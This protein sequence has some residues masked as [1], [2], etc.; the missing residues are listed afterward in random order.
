MKNTASLFIGGVAILAVGVIFLIPKGETLHTGNLGAYCTSDGTLSDSR[1]IQS[2]RS[3]CIRSENG[4]VRYVANVPARY[5]F[6]I[7]D[8]RGTT[9]KNFDTTHTKI[10]HVIVVRKDLAYFDHVHPSFDQEDGVFVLDGLVFPA[11][12]AYRV[13][14]DFVP[15]GAQ[16]GA[17]GKPLGVTIFEDLQVGGR[18]SLKPLGAER[19]AGTFD[20]YK[21][22][23]ETHGALKAGVSSMLMFKIQKDNAAV[24]NL[25][26]YLG[27][28]GHSV[29][30]RE[31]TLDFIHA[32]PMEDAESVQTGSV[33]F[34]VDFPLAGKYKVFGQ[35]Q[36]AGKVFTQTSLYRCHPVG[37]KT[38]Q[39]QVMKRTSLKNE[40]PIFISLCSVSTKQKSPRVCEEIFVW[41]FSRYFLS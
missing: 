8:D 9:V 10:M 35:F 17:G 23:L 3:Y 2:H 7:I 6:S 25:E 27:A 16:M 41:R 24:T 22:D 34:M 39:K 5:A 12:G 21:V 28:L 32:H 18:A 15:T 40:H 4:G 11:D 14:A 37:H 31:G 1:P 33:G 29:I 38:L 20:G 30:L 26:P 13:F 19:N 36:R